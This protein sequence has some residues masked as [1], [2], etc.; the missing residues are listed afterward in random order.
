[1]KEKVIGNIPLQG[2]KHILW[3]DLIVENTKFR[4]YL[5]MIEDQDVTTESPKRKCLVLLENMYRRPID[6]AQNAINFLNFASSLDLQILSVNDITKNI[7]WA[8]KVLGKYGL[9]QSVK[10][11]SNQ[12]KQNVQHFKGLFH[13][14]F[15]KGLPSFWDKDDK[16]ISQEN[17]HAF[18]MQ[19]R[20]DHSKFEDLQKGLK[21]ESIISKLVDDFEVLNHFKSIKMSVPPI[22]FVPVVEPDVLVMEMMKLELP[23][24]AQWKEI[25]RVGRTRYKLP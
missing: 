3:D 5:K 16:L 11:K 15:Q 4:Q 14:L 9:I 7:I 17:Y 20:M 13:S 2:A 8:R 6:T 23:M 12:L 25:E 10:N 24:D 18:L 21:G 1:L 22:S 19:I